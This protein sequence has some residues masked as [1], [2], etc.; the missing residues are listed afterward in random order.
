MRASKHLEGDLLGGHNYSDHNEESLKRGLS[1]RHIQLM[2]IGG[3][4]G[5]GLFMGSGKTISLSGVS[6]IL[7]YMIIGFF[8]FMVMRAMGELLLSN[9]NFKSFADFSAAYLGPWAGFF[10]GWSYWLT[11]AVGTIA[12]FVVI[13]G[14]LRFWFPEMPLW[15]PTL[16][17]LSLLLSLNIMSVKLFG[18]FEFWFA[19]IKIVAI[20]SLI[21]TGIWLICT[22]Y[23]SSDGVSASLT[24]LYAQGTFMP[25]GI[26]GFFAG[27]QIAIFSFAGIELIGTTAAETKNPEKTLPKAINAVPL[28]VLIF[29]V[30]AIAV[31]ISVSSLAD[32][33]PNQS[34]FVQLF[35]HA[36]LPAAAGIINIVVTT[37]AM[38]AANSG[39]FSTSR[40]LYGLSVEQDA[41]KFLGKLTAS[42]VPVNA[43]LFSCFCMLVGSGLLFIF[44]NVMEAFTLVTTIC[45]I[46]FI[47]TWSMII[48][49]YL[50]Y[51]KKR[52]DLHDRSTYKMP[53]G[54]TM[55]WCSLVFFAF[56][57]TLLLLEKDTRDA[58]FCMPIWFLGLW[59]S[60]KI[61]SREERY[62]ILKT[63]NRTDLK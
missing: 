24:N 49:S 6:I 50:V 10:I 55:C 7:T 13:G 14:Y 38:S 12:D 5:T 52:P 11:W 40:M 37:S 32:I 34:P 56:V 4:I 61:R 29:Y 2:S 35:L 36:G 41:P 21:A 33:S 46:L 3:A 20:L 8:L 30:A 18:E 63:G 48:F 1:S 59:F 23:V 39:V 57:L 54:I 22:S 51:R 42:S 17:T 28:R 43:I 62:T 31:V 16:G 53:Y 44:P 47:F 60:Y 9:S 19:S 15:I 25:H 58:L 45:A 27:F 26:M